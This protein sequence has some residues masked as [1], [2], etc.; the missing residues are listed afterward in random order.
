MSS[1]FSDPTKL[2]NQIWSGALEANRVQ[3]QIALELTKADIFVD[4][5]SVALG[6]NLMGAYVNEAGGINFF[7]K[8]D[9]VDTITNGLLVGGEAKYRIAGYL[10]GSKTASNVGSVFGAVEAGISIFDSFQSTNFARAWG[11]NSCQASSAG[12]GFVLYPNK[13]NTN[14]LQSVYAK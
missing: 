7:P 13:P 5:A 12:G 2:G 14:M 6:R 1:A 3:M 11:G 9:S 10:L 4:A 8:V